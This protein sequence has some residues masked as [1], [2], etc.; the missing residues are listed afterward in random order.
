M[1][2]GFWV[3]GTVALLGLAGGAAAQQIYDETGPDWAVPEIPDAAEVSPAVA[4]ARSLAKTTALEMGATEAEAEQAAF[5]VPE[6]LAEWKS[7]LQVAFE[8][9][10]G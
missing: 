1:R 7:P 8:E 4:R 9:H 6:N 3:W 2:R 10:Q 5:V